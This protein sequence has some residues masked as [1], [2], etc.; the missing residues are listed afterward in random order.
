[1]RSR[2]RCDRRTD[3]DVEF[4][5]Q[6]AV[7]VGRHLNIDRDFLLVTHDAELE[8]LARLVGAQYT[9]GMPHVLRLAAG[10]RLDNVAVS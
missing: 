6:I 10:D 3:L 9:Q 4:S 2:C 7:M 5:M 8:F 1:M